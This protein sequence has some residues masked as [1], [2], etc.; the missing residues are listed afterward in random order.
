MTTKIQKSNS[1]FNNVARS[2][3]GSNSKFS[4]KFDL[5]NIEQGVIIPNLFFG[6]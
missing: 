5:I 1:D 3:F 4:Y 6:E 2:G